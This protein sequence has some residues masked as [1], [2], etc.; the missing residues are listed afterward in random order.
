MIRI[1][2]LEYV[3]VFLAEQRSK[4]YKW[5]VARAAQ[6]KILL[7]GKNTLQG[8]TCFVLGRYGMQF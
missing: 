8:R 7:G 4:T 3:V 2:I 1:Y 5:Y 6:A